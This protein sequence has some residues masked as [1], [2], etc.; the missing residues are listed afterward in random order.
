MDGTQLLALKTANSDLQIDMKN[1]QSGF[2]LLK[3]SNNG[4][5]FAEK[6]IKLWDS[7]DDE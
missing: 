6:I 7:F 2:Y 3:I 5:E 4:R 1:F